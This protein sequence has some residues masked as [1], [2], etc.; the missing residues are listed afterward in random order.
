MRKQEKAMATM[1][2]TVTIVQEGRF[3]LTD[4][5]GASHLFLLGHRAAAETSQ[6]DALQQY[7]ARIRVSYTRT[8]DI[9]GLVA[10]GV[11]L[12]SADPRA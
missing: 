11:E 1:E 3:Q 7:Q 5:Q 12:M 10:D 4:R 6:L 2:G 8:R 9:L